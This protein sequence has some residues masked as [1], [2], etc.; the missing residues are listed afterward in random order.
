MSIFWVWVIV[1]IIAGYLAKRVIHEGPHG[2]L[3]DLVV[4]VIGA[5]VGGWILNYFVH[6][7]VTGFNIGSILVGFVGAAVFLWGL[8]LLSGKSVQPETVARLKFGAWAL[9][10]GAVIAM[11]I[12]FA[13]G[14]WST[15]SATQY[16][17]DAAVLATR[18]A[19]CVA[20]F[21]SQPNYQEKLKVLK[22]TS[23][24]ERAAVIEKGGWDRMPGEKEA[25]STVSRACA[26]GLDVL[27]LQK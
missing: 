20:Q 21:M 4:G 13:W 5:L 15:A 16:K 11:I 24:W 14:G 25:N 10:G 12:G 19:I 2:I 22:D 9:V 3:G 18:A 26:D 27:M 6:A 1:G 17:T 23:S 7:G 8:R